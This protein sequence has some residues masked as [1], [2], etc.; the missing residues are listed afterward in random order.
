MLPICAILSTILGVVG[1]KSVNNI[2]NSNK[3]EKILL[4]IHGHK[5]IYEYT[6]NLGLLKKH[7]NCMINRKKYTNA[8][9]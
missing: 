2:L 6:K 1:P 7:I 3:P 5:A 4:I 9:L 8:K